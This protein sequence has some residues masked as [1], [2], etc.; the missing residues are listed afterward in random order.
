MDELNFNNASLDQPVTYSRNTRML[1]PLDYSGLS[2]ARKQMAAD[3]ARNYATSYN[4][5]YIEYS[6]D[7]A[8]FVSQ[9]MK[10]AGWKAIG[11]G[12]WLDRDELV[13]WGYWNNNSWPN[14]N[15]TRTWYNAD[16]SYVFTTTPN[17]A[18]S[19]RGYK[20]GTFTNDEVLANK[21]LLE[22]GDLIYFNWEG[23]AEPNKD[24]VMIVTSIANGVVKLSGHNSDRN[25]ETISSILNIVVN[26]DSAHGIQAEPATR[27]FFVRT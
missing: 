27:W 3:Y 4:S 6:K 11:N 21:G 13:F 7:C 15:T 2:D 5:A 24:H 9:A 26:G 14:N 8:N 18:Y 20:L 12:S 1:P 19:T 23:P 10:A 22:V 16:F 25:N 17:T